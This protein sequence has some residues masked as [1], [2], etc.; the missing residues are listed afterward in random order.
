LLKAPA[1]RSFLSPVKYKT[2]GS[3][4]SYGRTTR[5]N[6]EMTQEDNQQQN[7]HIDAD[8]EEV[9]FPLVIKGEKT[10][11]ITEEDFA[12]LIGKNAD[13]Y[14]RKFKKFRIKEPDKFAISW[15]WPA[16]LFTY[17]WFAYRKMYKWAGVVFVIQSIITIALPF[18]FPVSWILLGIVANFLYFRHARRRILELKAIENFNSREDWSRTLQLKGGVNKWILAIVIPLLF[19]E[20]I[21]SVLA[22]LN[23]Q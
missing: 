12:N 16:F 21:L 1:R 22:T 2:P 23:M 5:G 20:F 6:R 10:I 13:V 18:L 11:D 4:R 14:F 15:N 19:I 8:F 3:D 9:D 17:I 7:R